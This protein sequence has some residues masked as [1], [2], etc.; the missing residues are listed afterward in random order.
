[1]GKKEDGRKKLGEKRGRERVGSEEEKER[2]GRERGYGVGPRLY[3]LSHR[4]CGLGVIMC[5][6][7]WG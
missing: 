4:V 6:H 1:M 5:E 2:E 7:V 3:N